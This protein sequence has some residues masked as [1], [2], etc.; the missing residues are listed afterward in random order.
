M[1]D[2]H[3]PYRNSR[4]LLEIDGVPRAGFCECRLPSSRTDV[5]EY[6]EGDE[7]RPTTRKLA[8]LNDYGPL[9]LKGG[10]ARDANALFEWHKM[11]TDGKLDEA[12]T[13]VAVIVLDEEGSAGAR[14]EFRN[15]WPRRYEA[16]R[17]DATG[18]GVAIET[19]EI[20]NEGFERTQ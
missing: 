2:T 19:V 12:R 15:A 16:P 1:T 14:W 11:V 7:K 6:R 10:V 5:V 13:T 9:V 4:F 20:V 18:E 3:G 17:L 8:G